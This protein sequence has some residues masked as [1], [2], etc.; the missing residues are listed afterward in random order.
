[1]KGI[2]WAVLIHPLSVPQRYPNGAP[3]HITLRHNTRRRLDAGSKS[4]WFV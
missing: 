3:H 1:M 2:I 4:H